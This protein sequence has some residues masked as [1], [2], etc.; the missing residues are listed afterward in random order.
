MISTPI[1]T[2]L[3]SLA[4]LTSPDEETIRFCLVIV[5]LILMVQMHDIDHQSDYRNALVWTRESLQL[6]LDRIASRREK[7]T[8]EFHDR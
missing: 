8:G 1:Q 6:E 2:A 3:E 4:S 7:I 5:D